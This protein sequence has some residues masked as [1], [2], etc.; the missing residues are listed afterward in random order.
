MARHAFGSGRAGEGAERDENGQDRT[1]DAVACRAWGT[2]TAR[3]EGGSFPVIGWAG[4]RR[5]AVSATSWPSAITL[6]GHAVQ[7]TI[8][9]S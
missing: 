8:Q 9:Y 7:D 1:H 2:T 5:Q 6:A 4:R 3:S